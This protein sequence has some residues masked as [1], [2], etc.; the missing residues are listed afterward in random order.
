VQA[1]PRLSLATLAATIS[2][3]V[4]G[5][6]GEGEWV[7]YSRAQSCRRFIGLNL[8]KIRGVSVFVV[9]VNCSWAIRLDCL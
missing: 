1:G 9:R 8:M 6:P 5:D 3:L 7:L 2:I 4:D